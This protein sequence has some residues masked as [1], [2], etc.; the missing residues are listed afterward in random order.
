MPQ[1][2]GPTIGNK[3][4][5][6][7]SIIAPPALPGRL[8]RRDRVES[9]A[10]ESVA[11]RRPTLRRSNSAPARSGGGNR[12]RAVVRA[13]PRLTRSQSA[14]GRTQGNRLRGVVRA[15]T[16]LKRSKSAPGRTAGGNRLR[17]V[18]RARAR[19]T[20]TKSA[21]GRLQGGNRPRGALKRSNSAPGRLAGGNRLRGVVRAR[22][23]LTRTTSAPGGRRGPGALKRTN[24]SPGKLGTLR[25]VVRAR[26]RLTRTT[27]A[28]G[29]RRG[30]GALKR[31]NS[32]PGKLGTLRGVVR[33]RAR[34]TR[35]TSAPGG[36]R[37]PGALK[38]T[39]SSPGRIN[40]PPDDTTPKKIRWRDR[41]R[42]GAMG[43]GAAVGAAG[44][45]MTGA[46]PLGVVTSA[47]STGATTMGNA[48]AAQEIRANRDPAKAREHRWGK[49]GMVIGAGVGATAGA[50]AG[51]AATGGLAAIPLAVGAAMSGAS[52]GKTMGNMFAQSSKDGYLR[53]AG[54][55]FRKLRHNLRETGR[56][57][58]DR[59]YQR[60][61]APDFAAT[62]GVSTHEGRK[63]DRWHGAG[64]AV[65]A[66]VSATGA[67]LAGV[68]GA[69][70][71]TGAVSAAHNAGGSVATSVKNV[72]DW[73]KN[74]REKKDQKGNNYVAGALPVGAGALGAAVGVATGADPAKTANGV[75]SGMGTARSMVQS[76]YEVSY[77]AVGEIAASK[78][79][80]K[81]RGWFRGRKN[82][83]QD[84]DGGGGGQGGG[85]G[86]GGDAPGGGQSQDGGGGAP[87]GGG[88]EQHG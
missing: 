74:K 83:G 47:L 76:A 26:A 77:V 38:R 37:G 23:K 69:A 85:Q 19:L 64:Y 53:T 59:N 68:S 28:P 50:I 45:I 31:T 22:A 25:G 33:A 7:Q 27:S 46:N 81:V 40:A 20:R 5:G 18:V 9:L 21:S 73:W 72:R 29:G 11:A 44:G 12:L 35:T 52:A 55:G 43:L 8:Q 6:A 1:K 78:V 41:V 80:T 3:P 30:P 79:G 51:V 56:R 13:R 84:Q 62:H 60:V 61:P 49:R 65:G 42:M 70:A 48:R 14:G 57:I 88:E 17:G 67:G 71:I 2:A 58:R 16:A 66:A 75:I 4:G 39:N 15:R 54:N 86:G 87:A 10:A 24:S 36:R 32:S 34:L 63:R 82:R